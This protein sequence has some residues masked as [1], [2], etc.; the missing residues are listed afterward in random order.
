MTKPFEAASEAYVAHRDKLREAEIGL[1]ERCEEVAALRRELP[2]GP[3]L[4][5][6][7]VFRESLADLAADDPGEIVEVGLA[8]LF[9]P[10]TT[11]LI[12]DHYMYGD[13]EDAGPCPMCSMRADGFNAI[14]RHLRQ[15]T[16]SVLVAKADIGRIRAWARERG[17]TDLRLLSS[18]GT[19][20]NRDFGVESE[21]GRQLAGVSVF[22]RDDDGTV[23]HFC[24]NGAVMAEGHGHG[25]DL[26]TPV[27]NLFDLLP[28]GRGE[29]WPSLAYGN[30]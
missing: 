24:T 4:V 28:D 6:D 5:G 11:S 20:F 14:V 15:R 9:A 29:W 2:A 18:G 27:W 1:K 13:G 23:R 25:I 19:S 17:W 7:Y 30:T 22:T 8:D 26:L 3:R 12:V 21:D 10:G 16:N